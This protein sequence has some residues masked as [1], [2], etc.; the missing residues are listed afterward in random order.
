MG[1]RRASIKHWVIYYPK[2]HYELNNINYFWFDRTS[3]T[4]KNCKYSIKELKKDI[5]KALTKVKGFTNLGHYKNYLK[6]MDLY[7]KKIQ[8]KTGEWKKLT[9]HQKTL[10]VNDNK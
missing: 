7:K 8:Y 6:K 5:S 2:F 1:I 3:W 4:K 10:A 9:F